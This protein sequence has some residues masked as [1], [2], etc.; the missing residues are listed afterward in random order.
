LI[1]LNDYINFLKC[2]YLSNVEEIRLWC[3]KAWNFCILFQDVERILKKKQVDVEG[4]TI[5]IE[6]IKEDNQE[7]PCTVVVA[8]PADILTDDNIKSL[9]MY[10]NNK[11]RSGGEE[12]IDCCFR[13]PGL[14]E[15]T[16]KSSKGN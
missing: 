8:G 14:V 7:E 6:A 3:A 16:F 15:V 5:F 1:V 4:H 10:F 9:K 13:N 12:V 11:R 2:I